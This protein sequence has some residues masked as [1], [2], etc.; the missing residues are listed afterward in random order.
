MAKIITLQPMEKTQWCG[1]K[2]LET[3]PL[4]KPGGVGIYGIDDQGARTDAL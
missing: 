2:G 4:V 1:G 3:M